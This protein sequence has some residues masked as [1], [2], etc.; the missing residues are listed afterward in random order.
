ML[1]IWTV[2]LGAVRMD[3]MADNEETAVAIAVREHLSDIPKLRQLPLPFVF[4]VREQPT[5][6]P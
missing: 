1:K 2:D 3:V 4:T 6:V 5:I